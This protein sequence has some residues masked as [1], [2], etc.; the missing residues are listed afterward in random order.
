MRCHVACF[1]F[2]LAVAEVVKTFGFVWIAESLD[3]FRY[4]VFE[5]L[6]ES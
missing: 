2:D 6:L 4:V 5:F 1:L 3:D